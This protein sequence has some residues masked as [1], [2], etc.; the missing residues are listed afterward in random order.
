MSHAQFD[1]S[2][3]VSMYT[4]PERTSICAILSLVLALLGCCTLVT[5]PIGLLL[6]VVGVIGI[7]RSK[8]RVGG[9]GF[10]IAGII[11]SLLVS[12]LALAAVFGM[13]KVVDGLD[14]DVSRPMAQ[15]LLDIQSDDFDGARGGLVKPASD[16]TD[17]EMIAFRDAYK[18]TLG[19]LI[20]TPDSVWA[21]FGGWVS[22]LEH[23]QY[24]QGRNDMMP[25]PMQ[26][27]QGMGL[28]VLIFN[29][30]QQHLQHYQGRNDMIPIPMQF[31]QGMGLV[32]LIFNPNQQNQ[33]AP[34]PQELHVVD[35]AGN[36][37]TLPWTGSATTVGGAGADAVDDAVDDAVEEVGDTIDDAADA[38]E[39]VVEEDEGP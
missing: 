22:L 29:P 39:D 3:H 11:I 38:V 27:D 12:V 7:A 13:Y 17:A 1:G 24:Y 19:E 15:V 23:L 36:V 4:E 33:G 18:S 10:A 14:R 6:G 21:Y 9:M 16:S 28:V 20:S 30:N 32:V 2:S 25:I 31:D 5:A 37:Y 35:A 34:V 26:F 8:G